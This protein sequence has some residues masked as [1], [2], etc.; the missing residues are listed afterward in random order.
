ML[1]QITMGYGEH[2]NYVSGTADY[3]GVRS[4]TI[5]TNMGVQHTYGYQ[6]GST[7][8]VPL[9]QGGGQVLGFFGRADTC[10][11]ALGAYVAGNACAR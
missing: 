6:S 8:S 7:F 11:V 3:T 9:R 5:E 1:S 2:V 10:L 4:L